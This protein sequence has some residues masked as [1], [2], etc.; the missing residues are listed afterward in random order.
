ME[1]SVVIQMM[2]E[3]WLLVQI[4]GVWKG[5]EPEAEPK[6]EIGGQRALSQRRWCSKV[7]IRVLKRVVILV[8]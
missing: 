2:M 7:G 6:W 8:H 4:D 1:V 5:H 3:C